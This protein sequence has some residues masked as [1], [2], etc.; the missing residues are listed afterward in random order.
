MTSFPIHTIE[1]AP[2]AAA[3]DASALRARVAGSDLSTIAKTTL[4]AAISGAESNPAMV[5]DVIKQVNNALG[6]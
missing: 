2:E 1:T 5:P 6:N 3:F 4:N